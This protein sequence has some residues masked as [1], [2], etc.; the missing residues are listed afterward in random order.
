M[1]NLLK[2]SIKQYQRG[3]DLSCGA[4][5]LSNQIRIKSKRAISLLRRAHFQAGD[6]LLREAEN[7]FRLINRLV[8]KNSHLFGQPFYKEAVEEYVEALM[9]KDFLVGSRRGIPAFIKIGPEEI[10]S[11]LCDFTG[12]LVRRA[13]TIAGP[14]RLA[15]LSEYKKIVENIAEEMTKVGF[16]GK[17][18]QKYDE[19]E[20]NLKR[21]EEIL[22]EVKMRR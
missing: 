10:I 12:E 2:K 6:K 13:V 17:L 5:R 8:K 1:N 4:E 19:V 16:K 20:R 21:L 14:E 9:L 18:R 7:H 11:G 22:Y 15:E 3:Q